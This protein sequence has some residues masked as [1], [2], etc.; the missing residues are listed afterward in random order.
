MLEY[1]G[2]GAGWVTVI[3]NGHSIKFYDNNVTIATVT[4]NSITLGYATARWLVTTG[5]VV[6]DWGDGT[7]SIVNNPQRELAHTYTDG[8]PN[9]DI[10]FIGIVTGLGEY[11]FN[12]CTCCAF[13]W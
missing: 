1:T 5:D 10:K 9:H 11:C 3:V 6:I 13:M 8:L 2:T 7:Q 12:N 4:G